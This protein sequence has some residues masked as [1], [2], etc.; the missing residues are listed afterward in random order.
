MSLF[1]DVIRVN[2]LLI[3]SLSDSWPD[4]T[5]N[6]LIKETYSVTVACSYSLSNTFIVVSG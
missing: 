5:Y 4:P 1:L 3:Q 2:P 6:F